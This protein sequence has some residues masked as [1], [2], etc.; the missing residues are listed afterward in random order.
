MVSIF[1]CEAPIAFPFASLKIAMIKTLLNVAVS[2]SVI[3]PET[4]AT[5]G[6]TWVERLPT[7]KLGDVPKLEL[8]AQAVVE[9]G[10]ETL[11]QAPALGICWLTSKRYFTSLLYR[12]D[13]A[14]NDAII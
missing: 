7:T 13:C 14:G 11:T 6:P 8:A 2:L 4:V 12:N 3:L 10:I 1:V 5:A 9:A